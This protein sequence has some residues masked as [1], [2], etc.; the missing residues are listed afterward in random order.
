MQVKKMYSLEGKVAV[1]T[2]ASSGLGV[3]FSEA[4]GEMGASI[5]LAARRTDKLH[6]VESKLNE[7]G[8]RARSIQCDVSKSEDVQ[9]LI[10]DTVKNFGRLDIIVNNAG[11]AAMSPTVD[12]S[13]EEWKKVVDVNLTGVFLCAR[14]AARQMM[15]QG[16]GKIINISS[17][18]GAV[19]DVFPASPYYA[20]K[21]AVINM[22]RDLAVEWAP[23]MIGVNAIAPGFFPS[24]MTQGIFEDPGYLEYIIKQTPLARTGRP[25][26]LKG[27]VVFLASSASDYV[28]GQTIFVDGGWTAW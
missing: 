7:T 23:Y 17:I 28:T 22:T 16:G 10:D 19:G 20:T 15:K 2:G 1:V 14:A 25:D 24:E 18:Y 5:E 26:D 11:V 9:A 4:L 21:G 12:I 3:V 6:E 27:V 13:V 8:V